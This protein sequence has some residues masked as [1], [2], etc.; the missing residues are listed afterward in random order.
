[1]EG[2]DQ[3]IHRGTLDLR[4]QSKASDNVE[5]R[6]VLDESMSHVPETVA[7]KLLAASGGRNFTRVLSDRELMRTAECFIDC[8]LNISAAARELYMH[9]NTM[10]YRLDK[11]K[12]I[13]GLDI[14]GFDAAVTFRILCS[15]HARIKNDNG[16][17]SRG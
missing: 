5:L 16:R 8:N 6:A 11:I 12:R 4:I 9:R 14:R 1:M 17:P 3:G 2:K 7:E 15:V 10:M 13:T